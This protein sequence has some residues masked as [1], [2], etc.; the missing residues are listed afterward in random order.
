[1]RLWWRAIWVL[2]VAAATAV[3]ATSF[4]NPYDISI[5]GLG[6][7][8]VANLTDPAV[9]RYKFL[10]NELAIAMSPKALAPAETLGMDGFEFSLVTTHTPISIHEDY[11]LGQ[12]GNPVFEGVS[13]GRDLPD[14]FWT[15]TAHLRKGL[16][17]SAE[18]GISGSYLAWS[19]IFALGA[20]FKLAL[21]ESFFRWAPALAA[22]MAFSRMFGTSDLDIITGEADGIMSLPFG[23]G[24]MAQLTP[25]V[26]FGMLFVHINSQVIDETPYAV[27]DA[28]TDQRGGASGSLYNFPTIEWKDNTHQRV[29]GGLRF[30]T[31]FVEILF[32]LDYVMVDGPNNMISYS[33]K[34]GFDV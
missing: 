29:F 23:I 33:V 30:I 3:P 21:H 15:P 1:M 8:R 28:A 11:W 34:L 18:I 24:G 10:S 13:R 6:R 22:R 16:P 27:R 14:T 26:G 20:E 5:R 17:L 9:Q 2:G 25:Y 19:E 4:A 7:P 31:A 12:P 32:Q